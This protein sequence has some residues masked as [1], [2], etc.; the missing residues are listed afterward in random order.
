MLGEMVNNEAVG[1]YAAA[2]RL[3][4]GWLFIPA[5]IATS[6]F[7]AMLNAKLKNRQL[8]LERTQYLFNLMA[9]IGIVVAIGVT[10]TAFP[11]IHIAFG[12]AYD[13]ASWILMVHIWGG[14]FS[15]MSTVSYRYFIA[16][17]L[18]K[19]SFYRGVTGVLANLMLNLLLIPIYGSMG[20]AIATVLSQIMAL[21]LF[22]AA[23]RKTREVFWMQTKAL[24]LSRAWATLK[25]I[26]DLKTE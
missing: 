5:V 12:P 18:Q 19:Y 3:S 7:P 22:N 21:Y 24:F 13:Q 14:I 23:G 15:A 25:H 26:N 11:I 1:I 8:Y 2:V 4:D 9:I 6:L 16:E 17:G 10:V 20:A